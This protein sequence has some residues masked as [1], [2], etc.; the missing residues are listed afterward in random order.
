MKHGL[1]GHSTKIGFN[2]I[3]AIINIIV[4]CLLSIVTLL[5]CEEVVRDRQKERGTNKLTSLT[6]LVCD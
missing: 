6:F 2:V 1:Q 3:N 4:Y 5:S